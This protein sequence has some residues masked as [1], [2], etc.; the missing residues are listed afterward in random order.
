[1]GGLHDPTMGGLGRAAIDSTRQGD[2]SE[3][4][5]PVREMRDASP[6]ATQLRLCQMAGSTTSQ[7]AAKG[8]RKDS[9]PEGTM[10]ADHRDSKPAPR[11]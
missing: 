7:G 9:L 10:P 8:T 11:R 5:R 6:L 1:M 2:S 4:I 3:S